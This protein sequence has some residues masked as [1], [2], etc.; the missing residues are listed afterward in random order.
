[1]S[2]YVYYFGSFNAFFITKIIQFIIIK[3]FLIGI[4]SL[5]KIQVAL[6]LPFSGVGR[7]LAAESASQAM[8]QKVSFKDLSSPYLLGVL[9]KSD[10]NENI[11]NN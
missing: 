7:L 5:K 1:M 9:R 4:K 10:A 8:E 11:N 3:V 6:L 2:S